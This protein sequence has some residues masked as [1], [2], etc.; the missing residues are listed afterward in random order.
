MS[1]GTESPSTLDRLGLSRLSLFTRLDLEQFKHLLSRC[2]TRALEPGEIVLRADQLND[3]MYVVMDGQLTIHAHETEDAMVALNEGQTLGE[4]SIIGA[5]PVRAL[6]KAATP[7]R[8]VVISKD[9][10]WQLMDSDPDFARTLV[11]MFAKRLLRVTNALP[12]VHHFHQ[13][14]PS[15]LHLDD[16]TGLYNSRCL[17]DCLSDEM[18]RCAM[19][20]RPL[21]V[22]AVAI[23]QFELRYETHGEVVAGQAL[24]A[25]ANA[26][27]IALRA[28]DMAFRYQHAEIFVVLPGANI[29]EGE[30]LANRLHQAVKHVAITSHRGRAVGDITISVGISEMTESEYAE[31]FIARAN[32]ALQRAAQ[33]GGNRTSQ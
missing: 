24:E 16:M 18:S 21:S 3:C 20:N 31:I 32:A 8:V 5:Q 19:R 4:M 17:N 15:E 28:L 12:Y 11:Q 22:L 1:Y 14:S 7:S 2:E 9:N 23:D 27:Q 29:F 13:Q 30:R 26:V 25:V 33:S 10:L 6:V